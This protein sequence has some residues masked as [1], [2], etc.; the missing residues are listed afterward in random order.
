MWTRAE[1]K[2]LRAAAMDWLED[3]SRDGADYLTTEEIL[4]FRFQ[5][6]KF[7]LMD[8]QRGIRKPRELGSALSIRTVW[9]PNPANAPYE[10]SHGSDGLIR[11]KWRGDDPEHPENRALR[12]AMREQQE[13]IWFMGV[14]QA[15]Y[16]PVFPLYIVAEEPDQQQFVLAPENLPELRVAGSALEEVTRRYLDRTTKQRLHQPMFRSMVMR[17]YEN[18]CAVCSLRHRELLDAAHIVEDRH[19]LGVAAIRNGL[20]LCKIHHAAY[21]AKILGIS[22]DLEVRI[23]ADILDEV[24]GPL[25][26]HGLK[27]LH[28]ERLRAV[29]RVRAE[30]PDRDLLALS[31]E[32]FL[33][34]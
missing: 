7:R 8:A 22:P 15:Q 31:F 13:I 21:D 12:A 2:A 6:E 29:P 24:D 11:Y 5:G 3:M 25:L 32:R 23:R 28:G 1:D 10:D 30:R 33:R 27:R 20:A 19:E 26:E 34:P 18:S 16:L 14:G 4:D 17:A 9:T